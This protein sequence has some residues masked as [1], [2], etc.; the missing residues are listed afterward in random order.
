MG[1]LDVGYV[2]ADWALVVTAASLEGHL[3]FKWGYLKPQ[4]REVLKQAAERSQPEFRRISKAYH[5]FAVQHINPY[6]LFFFPFDRDQRTS[7]NNE[8]CSIGPEGFRG[9]GPEVTGER[10]GLTPPGMTIRGRPS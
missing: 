5:P 3:A 1:R 6:Y 8:V 9:P 10:C 2:W 7:I 4:R